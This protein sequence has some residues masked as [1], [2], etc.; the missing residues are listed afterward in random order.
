MHQIESTSAK[1]GICDARFDSPFMVD[2]R[3]ACINAS[4][5]RVGRSC[6]VEAFLLIVESICPFLGT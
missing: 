5:F 3:V 4:G 6:P 1:L 2:V